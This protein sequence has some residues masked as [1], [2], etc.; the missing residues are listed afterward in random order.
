VRQQDNAAHERQQSTNIMAKIITDK[1][2]NTHSEAVT[3]MTYF[4]LPGQSARDFQ[5]ELQPLSPDAK[6]ELAL[7]AANAMGWKVTDSHAV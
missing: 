5:S 7:G 6:T 1:E 2:G 3:L 4:R